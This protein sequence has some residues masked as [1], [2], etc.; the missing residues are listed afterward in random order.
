MLKAI[1]QT[2]DFIKEKTNFSPEI[3]II[4]GTG[5]GGLV[6]EIDTVQAIPY[7]EIPNF[8][9]STVEGHKGQLIFGQ[10]GGKKWWLCKVDFTFM[11][12]TA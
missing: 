9:V 10:L 11:K 4:L 3:G 2:A 12:D 6:N 8:P 1:Q 7:E 5:L